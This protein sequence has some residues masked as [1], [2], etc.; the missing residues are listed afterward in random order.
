LLPLAVFLWGRHT[1]VFAIKHVVVSG[2]R[3][4]PTGEAAAVLRQH[5]DG[6]NLL[7]VDTADVRG[8]LSE[9]PYLR[10]VT[11]SRDFPDTLRVRL[12]EYRPAMYVLAGGRWYV[13]A[14]EGPAVADV[15]AAKAASPVP[16]ASASAAAPSLTGPETSASA[17]P[18][19]TGPETSASATPSPTG[20]ADASGTS[21]GAQSGASTLLQDLAHALP[22]AARHSPLPAMAYDGP[23]SVGSPIDD[24]RVAAALNLVTALPYS[25]RS[26]VVAVAAAS[27]DALVM[28]LGRGVTVDVGDTSR[29]AAKLLALR[30]VLDRYRHRGVTPSR[31]DVALPDRPLASPMLPQ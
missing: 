10:A 3:R 11:I 23:V 27:P 13:I 1:S 15:G 5:F 18:S 20:T 14:A 6:A 2:G 21:V 4:V 22:A 28:L 17:T 12:L 26:D 9:Y 7:E 29:L 31:I 24:E 19:P 30:A 16:Q 25:L 8:A